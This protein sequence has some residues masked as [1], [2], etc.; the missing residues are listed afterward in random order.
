MLFI[1]IFILFYF[2]FYYI[3][4]YIYIKFLI[5]LLFYLC[6]E[7]VIFNFCIFSAVEKALTN[8][9]LLTPIEALAPDFARE[10]VV[11]INCEIVFKINIEA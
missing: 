9:F 5:F 4:I 1:F 8:A 11:I 3:Y 6:G 2:I 7:E 10:Q